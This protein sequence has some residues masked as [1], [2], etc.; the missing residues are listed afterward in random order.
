MIA[1]A[2]IIAVIGAQNVAIARF[3]PHLARM[4]TDFSPA[5]LDRELRN[6]AGGPRKTIFFGDSVVWGFDLPSD[7]AA[8]SMLA[9]QGCAC[10][11]LAFKGGSP[12]NDFALV[13]LLERYSVRPKLL[14]LQINQKVLSPTDDAY[15]NLNLT[16]SA[17]AGSYFS[18]RDRALLQVPENPMPAARRSMDRALASVWTMYA[19]RADLRETFFGDTDESLPQRRAVASDFLGAYDLSALTSANVGIHFLEKTLAALQRDHIPVLAV[20]T[21]TNHALLHDSTDTPEYRAN[22]IYLQKLLTRYGARVADFDRAIPT[23]EFFDN[24]HMTVAGQRRFAS[25]LKGW[26]PQT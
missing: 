23:N 26:L 17:V 1:F 14:V 8:V 6:L 21:P 12:A 19:M 5:Y 4:T 15:K 16:L 18:A 11:N 22:G 7:Q 25:M 10:V 13:R 9:S 24:D 2:V 20:M 3:F